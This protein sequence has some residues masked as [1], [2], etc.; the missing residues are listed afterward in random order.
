MADFIESFE[1]EKVGGFYGWL[2]RLSG[3]SEP[4]GKA[5]IDARLTFLGH[6]REARAS[7]ERMIAW[8]PDKPDKVVMA[9]GRWYEREG[10]AE[11]RRAFRWPI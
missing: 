9:H 5:P 3:A 10:V 7:F 11:L 1:P 8:G 6:K 4:D 2:V